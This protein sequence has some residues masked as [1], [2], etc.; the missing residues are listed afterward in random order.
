MIL[1]SLFLL[2]I[3]I[4]IRFECKSN[5]KFDHY[6]ISY[7]SIFE[8]ISRIIY[9]QLTYTFMRLCVRV[10]YEDEYR[11]W[12]AGDVICYDRLDVFISINDRNYLILIF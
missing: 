4:K 10:E 5:K 2:F 1:F 9:L 11:M 6:L 12:Y 7:Q 3:Y 8:L